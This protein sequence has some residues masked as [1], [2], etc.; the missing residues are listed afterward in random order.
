M[1]LTDIDRK[2][3]QK[4]EIEILSEFDR[5]CKEYHIKYTLAGGTMLGAVRHKGFIPWDD[6][7]DVYVLRDDFIKIRKIFPKKLSSQYFYQYQ[8]TDNDYYYPFDKIRMNNTIFEETFLSNHN[9]NH[10]VFIDVFPI[11][12][13]PNNKIK[14]SVHYL[15]YRLLRIGLM[16]KYIN[17]NARKGKKKMAARFARMMFKFY[18]IKRLYDNCDALASKYVDNID[19]VKQVRNLNSV[20]SDGARETYNLEDFL[21]LKVTP[22]EGKTFLI[23]KNCDEMLKKEYGDY[24]KLPPVSERTTRHELVHVKLD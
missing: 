23:S 16:S 21:E 5:L 19:N 9:I 2:K 4:K 10:G 1:Q 13:I 3:V 22:F 7:I 11:D 24:M 20:G 8:K 14:R 6:D 17:I 15:H 18:P 12:A